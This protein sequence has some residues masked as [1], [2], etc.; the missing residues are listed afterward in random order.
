VIYKCVITYKANA[1]ET[2]L[3]NA[4]LNLIPKQV[5]IMKSMLKCFV[6]LLCE[7]NREPNRT[8][9]ENGSP[10][11]E[12]L[13]DFELGLRHATEVKLNANIYYMAYKDQLI[14]TGALD[15]VGAPVRE[16]SETVTA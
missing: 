6:F 7:S 11:P 13:N 8:D 2:G 5:L 9:Y 3:V 15:D 10:R 1:T 4:N 14:L 16:N 12:K